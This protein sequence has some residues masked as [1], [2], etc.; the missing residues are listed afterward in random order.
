MITTLI[1]LNIAVV[2]PTSP[3]EPESGLFPTPNIRQGEDVPAQVDPPAKVDPP[4]EYKG[5]REKRKFTPIEKKSYSGF[6][7][8]PLSIVL[9]SA[10]GLTVH[11]KG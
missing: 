3:S 11:T 1:L 7:L 8:L 6:F 5:G 10:M 9:V 4:A 2:L